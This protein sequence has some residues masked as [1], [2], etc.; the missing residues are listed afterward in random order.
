[1]PTRC[2]DDFEVDNAVSTLVEAQRIMNDKKLLPKVQKKFAQKQKE[3]A[4]AA[5]EVK[6]AKKQ[7]EIGEK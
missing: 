2:Q 1:M 5:L 4:A 7:R 3:L 6:V